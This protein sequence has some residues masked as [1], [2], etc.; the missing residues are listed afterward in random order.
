MLKRRDRARDADARSR[1]S[2][3]G[4]AHIVHAPP[5][6]PGFARIAHAR[7]VS[8]DGRPFPL[9]VDGDFVGEFTEVEFGVKPGGLL[10]VS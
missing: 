8:T 3:S 2:F 7:V 1:A 9:Q 4:R 6:G 10:A 5:P